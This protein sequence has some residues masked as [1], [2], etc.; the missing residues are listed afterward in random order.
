MTKQSILSSN[1]QRVISFYNHARSLVTKRQT[2]YLTKH[3]FNL[4]L[5]TD[6]I[7]YANAAGGH[8]GYKSGARPVGIRINAADPKAL[9][10]KALSSI[11]SFVDVINSSDCDAK[12]YI[13]RKLSERGIKIANKIDNRP[14][15]EAFY[16][17]G[18]TFGDLQALRTKFGKSVVD[19]SFTKL[20]WTEFQLRFG[21]F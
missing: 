16:A 6:L 15:K 10:D 12:E 11:E 1:D 9:R 17:E 7:D 2:A 5:S 13:E 19:E 20:F 4:T 14:A 21:E 8:S 3:S 18:K